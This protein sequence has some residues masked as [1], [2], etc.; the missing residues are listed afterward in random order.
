MMEVRWSLLLTFLLVLANLAAQSSYPNPPHPEWFKTI[1]PINANTPDWAVKMYGPNPNFFEVVAAYETYHQTHAFVKTVH[2]QNFKFWVKKVQHLVGEDGFIKPLSPAEEAAFLQS[3]E[4]R[5]AEKAAQLGG[6]WTCIGPFETYR[7]GTTEPYSNQ[8]NVYSLDQSDSNPDILYCGTESGAM[9][10]STDHGLTWTALTFDEVFSGGFG[11]LEIHPTNP[12]TVLI[13][14][15]NRIYRTVDGGTTWSEVKNLGTLGYEIKYRPSNPDSVFCAAD[16]GLWL[17]TDGGATWPTQV[18][19]QACHDLD[20]HTADP[21]TVYLLKSNPTLVRSEL[22]V[23]PNGGAT[24]F[25][26]DNGYYLP[27][28]PAEASIG[29]GKIALS[30]AD[31]DR[32]YVC[33]IGE[34]KA[35]DNGWIGVLRSNDRGESWTVPAGQYGGPYNAVNTMPWNVA[36]YSDGYHQG[37]YNFDFEVSQLNPDLMWIGSIRLS[38]S[39]D[40]G[41]SFLAIGAA[42]SARLDH[43]HA[44]IQDIEVNGNEIW[45]ANDG[46]IEYSTDAMQSFTSRKQGVSGSNYWGFGAGWNEDVL[47][48]GRYHV[49]NSGYYQT[50]G[51]GNSIKFGGVEEATGYVNPLENRRVY[52]GYGS[53]TD[54]GFAPDLLGGTYS[55]IGSLPKAPN[56]AYTESN[57]SG[58]YFDPRYA[59]HYFMG[60]GSSIWK[61]R[62]KGITFQSL[63]DFGSGGRTLEIEISRSNP[64]FI[65]VVFKPSGTNARQIWRTTDGGANWTQLPNVPATNRNKL[66]I[67]LNPSNEHDLWVCSNDAANGQKVYRLISNGTAWQNMTT[68]TLNGHHC[69]DIFYQGGS[70]DVVYV[71]SNSNLFYFNAGTNDWLDYGD[72]LPLVVS[73]L[74]MKPFFRD[75]KLRLATSGHGIWESPL[76]ATSQPVAQPITETDSVFCSRDTVQFESYSISTGTATYQWAFSPAPQWVSSLTARNPKVVFGTNGNFD[77]SLTVTDGGLSSTKNIVDMVK[78]NSFCEADTIPGQTLRTAADEDYFVSQ[79]ADLSNLTHFTVTGWWKPNGPQNAFSALFSSGDW[80]AHCDD[81]EGLIF[82]YFAQKLWYKWPGNASSWGSN[83]GITIPLN[84]WSYVALVIT[85]TSATM[86]LND[87]K[88]THNIALNPGQ[89]ESIHIG[90]G[91]YSSYFKGDIDEVTMWR[92]ALTEAEIRSLRHITKENVVDTDPDLIG[93]WQFNEL[94]GGSQVMDHAGRFH[95][96]LA[97]GAILANSTAPVGS[98]T[99]QTLDLS[100]TSFVY[101]FVQAGAKIWM[102]DCDAPSGTLVASRLNVA[103][104]LQPNANGYPSN[105]WIFN[106]YG[107]SDGFPP[108]DSIELAPTDAAFVAG[109]TNAQEGILHLRSQNSDANDWSTNAK[110]TSLQAG[111]LLFNRKSNIQGSTQIALSD[112][113]PSFSEMD[114]GRICEADTIPGKSL[115]LPGGSGNYAV[116]PTLNLNT[117]TFTASAWIKPNGLQN[118]NAGI[119]FCR[120]NSTTAGLH[121][122]NNNELRYHWD[123][124]NWGWGST[125]IAPADVWSHVALVVEPTKATIYLNGVP[126]TNNTSHSA[127]AFDY[128]IRIGNDPNSSSRTY[129]GEIDEV[130]LWNRALS[131]DEVRDLMHLTKEDILPIDP[132]LQVYLQFNE[133]SGKAYDK[134][135]NRNHA[136]FNSSNLTRVASACPVG[137]GVSNRQTISP[138]GG[139]YTFGGTG[140]KMGFP[141]AATPNGEVLVSR[142]NVPPAGMPAPSGIPSDS[143]YFVVRNFGSNASFAQLD[144]LV[145]EGIPVESYV[146]ASSPSDFEYYKRS[147][148]AFGNT[149]GASLDAA[150]QLY[151][152]AGNTAKLV[153]STNNG[154]TSFSQFAFKYFAVGVPLELLRF[155]TVPQRHAIDLTWETANELNLAGFTI[156]RSEDGQGFAPIGWQPSKGG[157]SAG[158]FF[159][160]E[161]VKPG[162]TY[163][164]RLKMQDEDGSFEFSP[165]R[166]AMIEGQTARL[167]NISPNPA[168]QYFVADFEATQ[169]GQA[170]LELFN[171]AGQLVLQ[172]HYQVSSGKNALM[173][174]ANRFAAGTYTVRIS[175]AD[176]LF[177]S[178]VIV[179]Q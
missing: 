87:Q 104:N 112:G 117:N 68:S 91:H 50:Y 3:L 125:A 111:K 123:G 84:E 15:N 128:P 132:A 32:V 127:E 23:S 62:D 76:A 148:N 4:Q 136:T 154:I 36:A 30:A 53:N 153:F 97:G 66:E 18:F 124:G 105:Y 122:K 130:C 49:G 169:P 55:V 146:N 59:E 108:F 160:D 96:A 40:G 116:V 67:T 44:D 12:N 101:D 25:L 80:C 16:N 1:P 89:I 83:S 145:F 100:G 99:S 138:G 151:N 173:V 51:V 166:Q 163:Y 133:A 179:G 70:A 176:G 33:L 41:A 92:R 94:V 78:V 35:D 88:Y 170:K 118:D 165:V 119:I 54:V 60:E 45:V 69:Y 58:L 52:F 121:I 10:K 11:A 42:N 143:L 39:S 114:P 14:V 71:V 161:A 178:Q 63:K 46:G 31:P 77:V 20:W 48:G 57:S 107:G 98:G 64:D 113:A 38:E 6:S 175:M 2:V 137:G 26:K 21:D 156:E 140:V 61:S 37:F 7:S 5:K 17:S 167:L 93:Y 155:E 157:A 142:L 29:G 75:G 22:F 109:L 28:I 73:P 106:L 34:S 19:S 131:Q 152:T 164:Y 139:V 102:S 43:L 85:P 9:Y 168:K 149:W 24:W 172:Q 141:A 147:S 158:Y 72:G 74:Q 162:Q 159:Q 144:S 82:D 79:Q 174:A 13:G 120:G 27:T 134:T 177:A 103:P 47:V 56:E 95:G 171:Q 135:P 110:A 150:D 90:K 86:Y 129:K 81:T 8:A 115:V 65:Y 126:F